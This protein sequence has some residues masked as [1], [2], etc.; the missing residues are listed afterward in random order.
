MTTLKI[1][2]TPTGRFFFGGETKF[3]DP[4]LDK[5]RTT[6]VIHSQFFP[7]QTALLGMLREQLLLQNGLLRH[8]RERISD[9]SAAHL[10]IGKTGFQ[11]SHAR[12]DFGAIEQLSPV[13]IG[14]KTGQ[15]WQLAPLDD[16]L[17]P[18]PLGNEQMINMQFRFSEI[19]GKPTPVMENYVPKTGLEIQLQSPGKDGNVP[20]GY[21]FKKETQIGI[22]KA[23]KPWRRLTEME[24]DDDE[25]LFKQTFL[26]FHPNAPEGPQSFVFFVTLK[27]LPVGQEEIPVD[28]K[29]KLP[30]GKKFTETGFYT[31]QPALINL[32][33]ERSGFRLEVS[34]VDIPHLPVR[35][36]YR[37]DG[38]LVKRIILT[39]DTFAPL[40]DLRALSHLVVANAIP[41]RFLSSI[42]GQTDHFH[43]LGK[44]SEKKLISSNLYHLLQ[45][46]GVIYCPE[47][48]LDAIKGLLHQPDFQ[49]IG[50]NTYQIL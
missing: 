5:R 32:G 8:T 15:L 29:R 25:G 2:L 26:R 44:S 40:H 47:K 39:S 4:G 3:G 10:L 12:N 41:F 19:S 31:L 16:C 11:I 42:I 17:M 33:G 30:D 38:A 35:Y 24:R 28:V 14:D 46:G 21:F 23:A 9:I 6:Y 1:T 27:S 37:Y 48:N 22:T 49:Q 20:I 45:R 34:E 43:S 18:G 13:F 7:Q 50:Y 36:H